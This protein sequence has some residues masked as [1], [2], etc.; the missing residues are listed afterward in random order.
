VCAP[1]LPLVEPAAPPELT[2]VPAPPPF[3]LLPPLPVSSEELL[4]EQAAAVRMTRAEPK[5]SVRM[6]VDPSS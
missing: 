3:D 6:A 2:G 4:L 1:A 5:K